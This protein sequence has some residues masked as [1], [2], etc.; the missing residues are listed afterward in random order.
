MGLH[1]AEV[2][3]GTRF[4]GADQLQ[5]ICRAARACI[6]IGH[7]DLA[8]GHRREVGQFSTCSFLAYKARQRARQC[9]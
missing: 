8:L 6:L 4:A 7:L 2:D 3:E 5:C 1:F 9:I